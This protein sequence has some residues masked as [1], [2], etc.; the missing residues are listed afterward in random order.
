MI[1]VRIAWDNGDLFTGTH[2][3]HQIGSDEYRVGILITMLLPQIKNVFDKPNSFSYVIKEM[4]FIFRIPVMENAWNIFQTFLKKKNLKHSDQRK[5]LLEVFITSGKHLTTEEL[6]LALRERSIPIGY[7]TVHRT[8]K[9][10]CEAGLARET[11]FEDGVGR[12]EMRYGHEHHDHLICTKCGMFIEVVDQKIEELQRKLVEHYGFTE[13]Y[14]R[15]E[16]YGI[17]K[18]CSE[19]EV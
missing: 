13:N 15:M 16:I 6:Y 1:K 18:K 10:L 4:N 7:T 5:A 11:K 2:D 14:H 9:L 12:Y 17:C 8:L 19:K 3:R